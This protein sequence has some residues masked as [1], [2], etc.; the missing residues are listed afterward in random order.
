MLFCQTRN[1]FACHHAACLH[2]KPHREKQIL[3]ATGMDCGMQVCNKKHDKNGRQNGA[4]CRLPPSWTQKRQFLVLY[5]KVLY[6]NNIQTNALVLPAE[7]AAKS[8]EKRRKSVQKH[9]FFGLQTC[10]LALLNDMF[11]GHKWYVYCEKVPCLRHGG[12]L[13]APH[14]A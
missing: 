4:L 2:G 12:M 14:R 6:V 5:I 3:R 7:N 10:H 8:T 9:A 1:G 11:T 13:L